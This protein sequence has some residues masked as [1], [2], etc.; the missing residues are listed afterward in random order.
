MHCGGVGLGQAL[1][2]GRPGRTCG[3]TERAGADVYTVSGL[4]QAV[5]D[6]IK[7]NQDIR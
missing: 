2:H 1:R 4:L 6:I 3:T 7:R 5:T